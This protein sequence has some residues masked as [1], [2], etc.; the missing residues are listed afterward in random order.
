MH[1]RIFQLSSVPIDTDEYADAS[2]VA[3]SDERIDYAIEIHGEERFAEINFLVEHILP[4][5]MFTLESDGETITYQGGIEQWRRDH[6]E[7]LHG[8]A[9]SIT[10]QNVHGT[11]KRYEL[12]QE[13]DW[14]LGYYTMFVPDEEQCAY[15]NG[16]YMAYYVSKLKVG[17]QLH[18]GAVFDYH[19]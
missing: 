19:H 9:N 6:V 1:S 3:D 13:I 2:S 5:G 18:V 15:D 12:K 14:P 10:S 4:K 7:R 17:D 16:N 11:I 8:V